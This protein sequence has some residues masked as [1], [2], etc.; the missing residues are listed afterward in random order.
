VSGVSSA[1]R[2]EQCWLGASSAVW[3]KQYCLV[4]VVLSGR[5]VLVRGKQVLARVSSAV[6]CKQCC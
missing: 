5:A 3:C 4:R 6:W 2:G 1:V